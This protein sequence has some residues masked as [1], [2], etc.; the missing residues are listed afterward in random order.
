[1]ET[2]SAKVPADIRDYIEETKEEHD[3]TQ[4]EAVRRLIRSGMRQEQENRPSRQLARTTLLLG[5]LM[6]VLSLPSQGEEVTITYTMAPGGVAVGI[7]LL[8]I[9]LYLYLYR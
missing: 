1:M 5:G 4:S 3:L 2:V 6:L 8:A 7:L 9:S